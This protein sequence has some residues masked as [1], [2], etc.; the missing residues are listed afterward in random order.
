MEDKT[1][2]KEEYGETEGIDEQLAP[3]PPNDIG[4]RHMARVAGYK[5]KRWMS[6]SIWAHVILKT[7]TTL[8]TT[9]VGSIRN[10]ASQDC[11]SKLQLESKASLRQLISIII[12][13]VM[14][15]EMKGWFQAAVI[16]APKLEF[17]L[18]SLSGAQTP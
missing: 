9:R 13:G 15:R 10:L 5:L 8:S 1:W 12:M 14:Q 18:T 6:A 17:I 2:S 16:L 7:L 11:S 3:A 4:D